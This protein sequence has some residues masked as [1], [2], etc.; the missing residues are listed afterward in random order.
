MGEREN[1]GSWTLTLN[2]VSIAIVAVLA[3]QVFHESCH[4]IATVLVGARLEWVNFLFGIQYTQVVGMNRWGDIIIAGNP[5]LMNIL[6]GLI[7]VALFSRLWAI[8]RPTLRLFLVYFSAYS[9]LTG[10]GNLVI[11]ALL[12]RP[13]GKPL[14]DWE[15]VLNVLGGSLVVRV[16]MG[17]LGAAGI[18]WVY[19]WLV[20]S[21]LKFGEEVTE[22][23]QRARLAGPLLMDPYLMISA[24]F[25]VVSIWNPFGFGGFLAIVL[26]YVFGY[27]AFFVAY[28]GVVHWTKV[29]IPL[30]DATPLSVQPSWPWRVAAMVALG[31]VITVLL[32]MIYF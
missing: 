6:T 17:L 32:P 22:R 19:S 21:T 8:R 30:P 9:L 13:G 11:N 16:A 1:G 27:V 14:G 4:A 7:A 15:V 29:R 23:H 3:V 20:R 18:V 24:I 26:Q 25:M 12:Y 10:F 2:A 5:A 28:F 31:V